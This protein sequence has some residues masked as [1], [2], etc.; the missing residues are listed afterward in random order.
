MKYFSGL[1]RAA[2]VCCETG[3]H[4]WFSVDTSSVAVFSGPLALCY[5]VRVKARKSFGF[6]LTGGYVLIHTVV[7][8]SRGVLYR[9]WQQQQ[10]QQQY[11]H[12]CCCTVVHLVCVHSTPYASTQGEQSSVNIDYLVCVAIARVYGCT[13]SQQSHS[14]SLGR[15]SSRW[16]DGVMVCCCMGAGGG[17]M[18]PIYASVFFRLCFERKR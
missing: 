16:C 3:N 4:G 7:A 12:I 11:R 2:H 9:R 10:Q 15:L 14:H 5:K 8:P 18:T 6:T 13:V 1:L 17:R